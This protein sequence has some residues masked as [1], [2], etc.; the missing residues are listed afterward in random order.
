MC[1]SRYA[2]AFVS[3]ILADRQFQHPSPHLPQMGRGQGEGFSLYWRQISKGAPHPARLSSRK[4]GPLPE[5][6]ARESSKQPLSEAGLMTVTLHRLLRLIAEQQFLG[7]LDGK[8]SQ[9]VGPAV[10]FEL[11]A[12][13]AVATHGRSNGARP[14]V[15]SVRWA[16]CVGL[17]GGT[18]G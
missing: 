6:Q 8:A 15:Q 10:F 7:V 4:S 17:P 1:V 2:S 12:G 5:Y 13:A 16:G 18:G 9:R 14:Q 11:Y 3:G